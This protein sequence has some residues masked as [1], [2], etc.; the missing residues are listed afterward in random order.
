MA[1]KKALLKEIEA[2]R[3]ELAKTKEDLGSA[4]NSA[5]TT[6]LYREHCVTNWFA[7]EDEIVILKKENAKLE[8]EKKSLEAENRR[9]AMGLYAV[10]VAVESKGYY[11]NAKEAQSNG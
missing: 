5:D 9:L 8:A 6:H 10:K 2:L 3:A 11:L 4:R 7:C 1:T